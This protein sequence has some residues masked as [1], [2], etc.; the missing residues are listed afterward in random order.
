MSHI[1]CSDPQKMETSVTAAELVVPPPSDGKAKE[2]EGEAAAPP[3]STDHPDPMEGFKRRLD[4]I[5]SAYGSAAELLEQQSLMEAEQTK[6]EPMEDV[7]VAMETE[8]CLIMKGLNKFSSPDKKLDHLVRKFAEVEAQRRS[9]QRKLCVLQKKMA[10]LTE[11]RRVLTEER[12]SGVGARSK[13]EALCRELQEHHEVLREE[14][15]RRCRA[16]EE[17]RTE[18][19]EHFQAMLT[20]IQAQIEQHSTRN[21]KL[22]HE[23]SSLTDKLEGLMSQ[24]EMREESL[25]KINKHRELQHKLTEAKLQQAH[26]LLSEAAEKHKR[27]K[28]YLL[29]QAAEW[30]LQT[31]T[32]REQGAVMQA[33][34]NLYAQKFD[35]FQGTLAKSNEIYARFKKEM[36]NMS[37]K[38]KKME[39]ESTLWRT[40]FENCNKALNDMMEEKAVKS[41]EYDVFV[42]KIHNL[43]RLC[44]ALQSERVILYE[45]IKEVRQTNSDISSKAFRSP[46]ANESPNPEGPE[47]PASPTTLD[48]QDFQKEELVLTEGMSRLREEQMKLQEIAASL[49][50]TTSDNHNED[51][52]DVEPEE[53]LMSSAF[54]QFQTKTQVKKEAVLVQVLDVKSEAAEVLPHSDEVEEDPKP[55]GSTAVEETFEMIHADTVKVPSPV[56]DEE[57]QAVKPCEQIQQQP[58]EQG[59]QLK[60]AQI[61]PPTEAKPKP[62]ESEIQPVIPLVDRKVQA[63]PVQGPEEPPTESETAPRAANTK[64]AGSSNAESSKKQTPK[65]KKKRNSK[66]AS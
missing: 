43:E 38:M 33:Q 32:L 26:A 15:L 21:D 46:N 48:L 64:T 9:D 29:V 49:M 34:L 54:L 62:A 58:D 11:E 27:E 50:A 55:A 4:D 40:R 39:K 8:V 23:N 1:G 28:E 36:D 22:C 59:S 12:R 24:C 47:G 56:H 52:A 53:D 45:K 57:V 65:K 66:N 5:I 35:E 30:K 20:E 17:K 41:K 51:N 61:N 16:D 2:A 6:K 14:N 37:E 13:L 63:E 25:E 7:P 18:I 31:Q 3:S 10:A 44:H 60:E 42:L 19:T